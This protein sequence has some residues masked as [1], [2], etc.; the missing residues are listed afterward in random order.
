V[1]RPSARVG[2]RLAGAATAALALAGCGGSSGASSA[3]AGSEGAALHGAV[4]V[5][6]ASSL[7]DAFA[8]IARRFEAAHPGV[9]VRLSFGG[10]DSLAAQIVQGAPVDVFAAASPTTMAIVTAAGDAVGAPRP[11]ATNQLEIAVPKDNPAHVGSLLDT[12]RAGVKLALCA[13]SVPCGA[14]AQQAYAASDLAPRPVTLESDVRSVLTKVELGEVDAGLVY[15]TD[16]RAAGDRVRGIELPGP[17]RQ[18]TTYQAAAVRAGHDQA[19]GQA[20]VAYLS[21]REAQR[22]LAAAGFGSV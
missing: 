7:T 20:F 2:R 12:T 6:A 18:L 22:A 9:T 13:A 4:V 21:S 8:T 1:S 19:A 15:R 11:F 17:A 10:S 5:L 16:V 14:A 3:L